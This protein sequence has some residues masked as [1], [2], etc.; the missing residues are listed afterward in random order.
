MADDELA[1]VNLMPSLVPYA[2][3]YRFGRHDWPN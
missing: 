1:Q 2:N 3:I